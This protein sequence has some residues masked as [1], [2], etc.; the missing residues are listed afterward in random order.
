MK[1]LFSHPERMVVALLLLCATA[2]SGHQLYDVDIQV[3]IND[4]GHARVIETRTYDI[5]ASGTEAYIKMYNLGAMSVG[6]LEV[7]DEQGRRFACDDHWD[8]NRSRD[9]KALH[10]G[11]YDGDE[12]PELCW[13][14]GEEG[15]RTY[16]VRYTLSR[17]VKSYDDFDGFSFHFFDASQPY[18]DHVRVTISKENGSFTFNDTRIWTFGHYGTKDIV[19]GKIVAE[20]EKPLFNEHEKVT[21]TARFEKGVFHP[22]TSI[23]GTYKDQLLKRVFEGSSYKMEDVDNYDKSHKASSPGGEGYDPNR[24]DWSEL[25]DGL[26]DVGGMILW[27]VVPF[28]LLGFI[29]SGRSRFKRDYQLNRLFG[30]TKA[31]SQ[32]WSRDIPFDGDLNHTKAVLDTVSGTISPRSDQMGAYI[33]RMVHQGRLQVQREVGKK[34]HLDRVIQIANPGPPPLEKGRHSEDQIVYL[35]QRF[36]W[37]VAGDDHVLQPK[38][39]QAYAKQFPVEHRAF[40]QQLKQALNDLPRKRI[41]E[42]TPKEANSVFGL[43]KFLQE[44]TLSKERNIEE[45]TIWKEYLVHAMLFG[46]GEQVAKNLE[47]VWP[48]DVRDTLDDLLDTVTVGTLLT[49]HMNRAVT[50][51]ETYETPEEREERLAA[52]RA[53]RESSS[54]GSGGSSYGGGGGSSGGGGSGIR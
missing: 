28:A 40:V 14:I 37:N 48:V 2:A 23:K 16:V 25:F 38:E 39:L 36:M 41:S 54:G 20:T 29:S 1:R 15:R 33:L 30:A 4:K 52:E 6:E 12:G 27:M 46:I 31:E 9:E 18:P 44:F 3:M 8:G 35:L 45:V 32:Q 47:K 24:S 26:G 42:I 7:S 11:I 21:V 50:Y 17:M 43:K 34:G 5:G 10:C 22:V 13:G 53:A 19:D 49:T 51:I